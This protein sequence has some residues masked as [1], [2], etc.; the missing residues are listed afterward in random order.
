ML[1]PA[2]VDMDGT[3]CDYEGSLRREAEELATA[4]GQPINIHDSKWDKLIDLIKQRP[5]FWRELPPIDFGFKVVD[6][7][8]TYDFDVHIL[9]KGPYRTTSAWTEKVEW[10]RKHLPG[11][12][13]TITE[14]KGMVYGKVLVDD[15]IP[16]CESWMKW[17]PRGLVIMPAHPYND[18]FDKLHP[19]RVVRAD[20]SSIA[21]VEEAIKLAAKQAAR[22]I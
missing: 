16:Y 15:W 22:N 18:G 7:L 2:L 12:P 17:R 20:S 11:I 10:C 8:R 3:L 19:G 21:Q 13:V 1:Y 9:T 5:G 6:L 4:L 14:N